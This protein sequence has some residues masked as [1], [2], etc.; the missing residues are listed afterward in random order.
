MSAASLIITIDSLRKQLELCEEFADWQGCER[1]EEEIS[2]LE[3]ILEE[4]I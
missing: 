2:S 3:A 4:S 1:I